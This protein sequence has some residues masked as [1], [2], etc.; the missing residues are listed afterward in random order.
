[1]LDIGF[2]ELVVIGV[3]ALIV[4]G[5]ERLPRVARTAGHLLGR[6]QRYVAEVKADINREIELSELKKLRSTVE[7][8]ARSIEHDVKT[9]VQEAEKEFRDAQ[10]V[11]EG[12]GT[13]LKQAEEQLKQSMAEITSPH[14]GAALT[15]PENG[16]QAEAG[17]GA[18]PMAPQVIP[19]NSNAEGGPAETD[20][21]P[22]LELGLDG[23]VA[24]GAREQR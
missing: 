24:P 2:S 9:G 7:D 11:L 22:Q 8:A 23:T 4:I 16:S 18:V 5:P 20:L 10:T 21:S 14:M 1:M 6:F 19:A 13:E 3:V 17:T 12:A 15:A